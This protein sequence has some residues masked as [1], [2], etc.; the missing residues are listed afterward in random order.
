MIPNTEGFQ[1]K[2]G[3]ATTAIKICSHLQQWI[4]LSSILC[5]VKD[6]IVIVI[7]MNHAEH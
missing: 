2:H 6:S 1:I 5:L 7:Q 3:I 4:T